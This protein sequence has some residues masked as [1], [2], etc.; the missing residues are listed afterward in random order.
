MTAAEEMTARGYQH[1]RFNRKQN[2]ISGG[3]D[4]GND[5]NGS[6]QFLKPTSSGSLSMMKKPSSYSSA[7]QVMSPV[8][9]PSLKSTSAVV[10]PVHDHAQSPTDA[11]GSGVSPVLPRRINVDR[12]APS[13]APLSIDERPLGRASKIKPQ[14]LTQTQLQQQMDDFSESGHYSAASKDSSTQNKMSN[15][16]KGM[17]QPFLADRAVTPKSKKTSR[18]SS[19]SSKS[20]KPVFMH[21]PTASGLASNSPIGGLDAAMSKSSSSLR[22]SLKD[23]KKS[24]PDEMRRAS[25]GVV[26]ESKQSK[27]RAAHSLALQSSRKQ[28]SSSSLSTRLEDSYKIFLLLLQPKSKIFELIQIIYNPK[29][30]TIGDMLAMI[31]KNATE[32]ALGKQEYIGLCRPKEREDLLNMDMLASNVGLSEHT[33]AA[34]TARIKLGEILVA[35][36]I[37]YSGDDVARLSEQI[38]ANPKIVK[39]LKRSDPLAPKSKRRSSRRHRSSTSSGKH[40]SSSSSSSSSRSSGGSTTS[41][42]RRRS[43]K[44]KVDVLEQ[45]DERDEIE[46]EQSERKMRDAMAHAAAEAAAANAA[47]PESPQSGGRLRRLGSIG[48]YSDKSYTSSVQESLDESYSSWSKS[49]EESFSAQSSICSGV[50]KRA[51]RRKE[52]Q[53]RRVNILKKTGSI[54]FGLMIG[55]FFI[56][57]RGYSGHVQSETVAASPMGIV[58]I[59]QTFFL[60]LTIYKVQRFLRIDEDHPRRCP[61]LKASVHAME[62]LKSRYAKKLAPEAAPTKLRAFSLKDD[63]MRSL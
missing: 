11:D 46:Q 15:A 31:P 16:M 22:Y 63:D 40:K 9:S 23:G 44:S 55:L 54:A 28:S 57:P 20:S 4:D 60:L 1:K 43:S 49:F 7:K 45:H 18:S 42:S 37:G 56:D 27:L 10:T 13:M 14:K 38:L 47:I 48:S 51:V 26:A 59:F 34:A 8:V 39:L 58:G 19:S 62:R 29:D 12:D 36:P 50:S 21:E 25:D 17:I 5:E 24:M 30:T 33:P 53:A 2:G 3:S 61:F 52:R 41:S 32:E 6:E 35:I